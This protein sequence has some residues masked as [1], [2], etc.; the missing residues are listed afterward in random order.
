MVKAKKMPKFPK[1]KVKPKIVTGMEALGRG[2]DLNKLSQFLEYLSPL[3][4]EVIAQKLNIDDYM[5]RLG[6]SLGIDTGGLIKT[7]EQIQQEQAEAMEQQ[8][9]DMQEQQQAQMMGD[10]VKGATPQIAKGMSEAMSQNPEMMEQMQ[11]AMAG[12]A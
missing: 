5:D 6:A 2:Q 9:A 12:Q 7:D 8:K 1:D 11:Q 4:P 3:G 10:V